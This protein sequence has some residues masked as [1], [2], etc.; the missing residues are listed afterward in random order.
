MSAHTHT[1]YEKHLTLIILQQYRGFYIHNH[2][3]PAAAA[4][5][6]MPSHT[7]LPE[8]SFTPPRLWLRGKDPEGSFAHQVVAEMKLG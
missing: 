4:Q 3:E 6:M 2:S 1:H 7:R 8:L 5:K